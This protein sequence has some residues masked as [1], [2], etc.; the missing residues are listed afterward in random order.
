MV[1]AFHWLFAMSEYFPMAYY[2]EQ[3]ATVD[4]WNKIMTSN[5]SWRSAINMLC[6]YDVKQVANIL[7][8]AYPLKC[9]PALQKDRQVPD[10]VLSFHGRDHVFKGGDKLTTFC[11]V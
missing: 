8:E 6:Y 7:Q 2:I 1:T 10:V 9:W 11:S 4:R 3:Y 5:K